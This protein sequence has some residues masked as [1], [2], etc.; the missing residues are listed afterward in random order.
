MTPRE[1]KPAAQAI[2]EIDEA[3]GAVSSG[4]EGLILALDMSLTCVG[5][6][7]GLG[8]ELV[9]FGK[10][11]FKNTAS[12]GQKLHA[13]EEWLEDMLVAFEPS[14]LLVEQPVSRKRN[15]TARHHEM[16]GIVKA[17]WYEYKGSD[18][19]KSW[20]IAPTTVKTQLGVKRG[21]DHYRNKVIMVEK[22]NAL[23]GLNLECHPNS[24]YRSDDDIADAIGVLEA[25]WRINGKVT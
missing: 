16:L 13:F 4:A 7:I 6:A 5:W 8:R 10:F 18:I 15:T 22:I 9:T 12:N 11:V 17:S 20:I 19:K 23:F 25:Y 14:R 3:L 24:A 1:L 2:P 21:K